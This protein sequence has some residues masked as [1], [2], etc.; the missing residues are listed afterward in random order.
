MALKV[1][2]EAL[3]PLPDNLDGLYLFPYEWFCYGMK[4]G[5]LEIEDL[6]FYDTIQGSIYLALTSEKAPRV[7]DVD[8]NHDYIPVWYMYRSGSGEIVSV[9]NRKVK[10]NEF[11][12]SFIDDP[13]FRTTIF[14]CGVRSLS[15]LSRNDQKT[16]NNSI[17]QLFKGCRV[18]L[19]HSVWF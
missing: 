7:C 5:H 6:A 1:S 15:G 14:Y 9:I 18:K 10:E 19:K 16:V 4:H 8:E 12:V 11:Q 2:A 3:A 13:H 17:I